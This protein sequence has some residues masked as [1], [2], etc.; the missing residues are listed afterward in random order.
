MVTRGAMAFSW[1]T[2]RVSCGAG[3][4]YVNNI[5]LLFPDQVTAWD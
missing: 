3:R 5:S 4:Q 1:P 2:N